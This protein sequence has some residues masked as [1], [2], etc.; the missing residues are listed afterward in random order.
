M[1]L[2]RTP[3]F[4]TVTTSPSL[5]EVTVVEP[6]AHAEAST[7]HV[8]G[9]AGHGVLRVEVTGGSEFL[10]GDAAGLGD[11]LRLAKAPASSVTSASSLAGTWYL[12][13]AASARLVDGFGPALSG[14][15]HV[16]CTGPACTLAGAQVVAAPP[17]EIVVDV[18][19]FGGNLV[20][21]TSARFR[22]VALVG[23]GARQGLV[24]RF[25]YPR[26]APAAITPP[27]AYVPAP[28]VLTG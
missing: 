17:G 15:G 6:R 21:S 14:I 28:S 25:A 24:M 13:P 10:E 23:T 20:L 8:L 27:T 9:P 19:A 16:F 4:K 22:P 3:S 7:S 26:G 18:P 12:E 5:K 11:L 2:S 1:A